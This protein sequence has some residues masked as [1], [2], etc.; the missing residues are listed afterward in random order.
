MT[1]PHGTPIAA[2]ATFNLAMP[3]RIVRQISVRVPPGPLGTV[4]FQIGAAGVQVIP[5]NVG[6]WVV[7]NDRTRY[8][9][10]SGQID[11]GAWQMFAYNTGTN[12][13]T[14]YIEFQLE[15]LD[16]ARSSTDGMPLDLLGLTG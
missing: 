3:A 16:S 7:D 6:A 5:W 10:V 13:H 8:F 11:T 14:L 12:D 15:T 4:G 1:V 9:P 2:P